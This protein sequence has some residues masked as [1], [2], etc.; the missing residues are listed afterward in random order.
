MET[1][2]LLGTAMGLGFVAGVNLYATI[3][4]V[5]L[6]LRL[7]L[8]HL[9]GGLHGLTVLADPAVLAVAGLL[10]TVEFFA[11]KVPWVDSAWDVIHTFI[12]PLGA[13]IIAAAAIGQVDPGLELACILLA[14][15]AA[16]ST[17]A[18]KA[19]VRLAV[20]GSPEPFS[21]IGL[22]LA[23]DVLVVA[24]TWLALSHPVLMG[25]VALLFG[26]VFLAL[27][28]R[29]VRVLRVMVRALVGLVRRGL[30]RGAAPDELIDALPADHTALLPPRV[31]AARDECAVRGS[32]VR[33]L[34]VPRNQ[35]GFLCLVGEELL[36]VTRRGFR[37]RGYPI[38]L[39]RVEEIRARGGLM[40]DR[41]TF[42][43]GPR[44]IQIALFKDGTARLGALVRLLER[45]RAAAVAPLPRASA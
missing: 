2:Y 45:A 12:R 32:A 16:L 11:D 18:T 44:Q 34:P 3:L 21:N 15:G 36:F 38:D 39:A 7:G 19:G 29:L 41:L 22:S 35:L 42:C 30:G 1:L 27:A 13:A 8:I 14:G 5:G 10:Y 25:A 26:L 37:V 40:F 23:E 28:P 6:A 4:S 20:N 9:P 24:G 17:H 31:G 43:A 33:G